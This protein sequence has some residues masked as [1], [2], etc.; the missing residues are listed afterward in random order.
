MAQAVENEETMTFHAFRSPLNCEVPV[1]IHPMSMTALTFHAL[2]SP[3]K[4]L[5]EALVNIYP[6][7]VTALT[8]H[9]LRSP[10]K[11]GLQEAN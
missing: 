11:L 8:F 10:L 7:S 1:N 2:R 3:L 4:R 5:N 9:V 6:I